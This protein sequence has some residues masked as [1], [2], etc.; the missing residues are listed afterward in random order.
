MVLPFDRLFRLVSSFFMFEAH[1][2]WFDS[3][4]IKYQLPTRYF[5][6]R[7]PPTFIS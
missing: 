2:E 4:Q 7:G 3:F 1:A 6:A 5:I